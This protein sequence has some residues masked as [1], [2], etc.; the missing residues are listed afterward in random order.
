VLTF[1]KPIV[2]G[3]WPEASRFGDPIGR[4]L[5]REKKMALSRDVVDAIIREHDYQ[6]ITGDVLL[7]GQQAIALSRDVV[8]ELMRDLF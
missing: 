8:L 4:S 6:L 7:I 3:W 2:W 5:N 1:G